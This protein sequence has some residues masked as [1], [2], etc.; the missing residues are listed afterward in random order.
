MPDR[1]WLLVVLL[2]A[3][4]PALASEDPFFSEA[5][6]AQNSGT[7]AA[8]VRHLDA[9]IAAYDAS[10][11]PSRELAH[12]YCQR[13]YANLN[14][15]RFS[16]AFADAQMG[17]RIGSDS[18]F[19]KSCQYTLVGL[20]QA[21]ASGSPPLTPPLSARLPEAA[22]PTMAARSAA[23]PKST[24]DLPKAALS[25]LALPA[26]EASRPAYRVAPKNPPQ[27]KR[28]RGYLVFLALGLL[29]AG[30]AVFFGLRSRSPS[31][32]VEEPEPAEEPGADPYEVLGLTPGAAMSE[33][34]AAYRKLM[35]ENHP[36]KVAG[37]S[38]ALRKVALAET[39]KIKDAYEA[40]KGHLGE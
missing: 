3:H 38:A 28:S 8:K 2:V 21:A 18:R 17:K 30:T 7:S 22:R 20:S 33:V 6:K 29:A 15:R 40:L 4:S 10:R 27:P 14:L 36:D 25:T 39:K 5:R 19:T 16:K 34:K 26:A 11:H 31:P 13:S 1:R 32:V 23:G 24:A 9:A 12:R 37:L 35:A